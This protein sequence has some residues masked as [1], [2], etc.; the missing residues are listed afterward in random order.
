MK[1]KK[2]LSCSVFIFIGFLATA[3]AAYG[4]VTHEVKKGDTLGKIAGQYL[5]FSDAYTVDEFVE[6]IRKSNGITKGLSIGQVLTIPVTR[7]EP[8]KAVSV[9]KSKD[10]IARGAYANE[11]TAGSRQIFSL[12]EK[13]KKGGGNTIVFDA[14]EV[15][16]IPTYKSTISKTYPTVP[17]NQYSIGDVNKLV[18]YLHRN[19]MHVVARVCIFRDF[20][21]SASNP[22]WR[23]DKEW[24]N[25]ANKEVQE[26][27]LAIIRELIGF[28]VD[29][30]QVDYFRYPADGKTET[31]IAGKARSDVL[32]DFA[33]RIHELTMSKG[34]LLSLDMF[35]IVNWQKPEDIG[36]LGQ[37]VKKLKSKFDI[38]SPMLYPSHFP[39]NFSG[40]KNPADEP[41][42]FVSSG[43]K[44]M[45]ALV[46]NEVII[47]TW[48]QAFPLR[49]KTG[50]NAKYVRTQIKASDDMGGMGWLLWSPGNHYEEAYTALEDL[51][52]REKVGLAKTGKAAK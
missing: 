4:S 45:K 47:R 2:L 6:N 36:T 12:C 37:D 26:Y 27:N 41:Y 10:F 40:V 38:I 14:K 44:R 29:E 25:P 7:T 43:V 48:V 42:L 20:H 34:I 18:D 39:A 1:G 16:G 24:V 50:Y 33:G 46:G 8:V 11:W 9:K 5:Q 32:A 23:Y 49:V 21:N 31:G 13:L 15:K 3:L 51:P 19:G 28:G 17:S 35:G 30:I 22:N 52:G